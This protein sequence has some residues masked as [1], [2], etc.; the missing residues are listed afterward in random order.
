M[1]STKWYEKS[2]RRNR[3]DMHIDDWHEDFLS[4]LDPETYVGLLKKARVQS[5]MV[6][7]EAKRSIIIA[8]LTSSPEPSANPEAKS[9]TKGRVAVRK[10]IIMMPLYIKP[11]R[12]TRYADSFASSWFPP[13]MCCATTAVVAMPRPRTGTNATRSQLKAIVTAAATSEP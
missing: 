6:Y 12:K 7:N 1:R 5:A 9:V 4:R 8:R 3:V 11:I 2:Y 13:P 10:S